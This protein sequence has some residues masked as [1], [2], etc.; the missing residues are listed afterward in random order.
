MEILG[1]ENIFSR[2]DELRTATF[3]S[4]V[5]I[6]PD[7]FLLKFD[8]YQFRFGNGYIIRHRNNRE[9]VVIDAV[10]KEHKEELA[11]LVESGYNIRAILLTHSDLIDQAYAPLKS[12]MSELD[13]QIYIHSLDMQ[14]TD[15]RD[16]T[17]YDDVFKEFDLSIFHTPGH[18][19]GS[20][21]IYCGIHKTLFA[22]DSA[23]G[24]PYESDDYYFDRP[25][26]TS[27][28]KD[29]ALSESWRSIVVEFQH[30][31]PLHGK[32]QFDINDVQRDDI[33][34]RLTREEATKSL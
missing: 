9:L 23:V 15:C 14:S 7:T 5:K 19:G 17:S 34:R 31:L 22:G 32:P 13:T 10:R 21:V 2:L 3:G 29:F 20:V 12:I 6:L 30:L 1:K 4:S 26:I 33:L 8:K 27:D 25:I 18:T 24:A 11:R 16:I 28:S